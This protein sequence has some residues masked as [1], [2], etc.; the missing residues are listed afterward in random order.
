[1]T[2]EIGAGAFTLGAA[3]LVFGLLSSATL[4]PSK[5]SQTTQRTG[6]VVSALDVASSTAPPSIEPAPSPTPGAPVLPDTSNVNPASTTRTSPAPSVHPTSKPAKPTPAPFADRAPSVVLQVMPTGTPLIVIADAS[7]STDADGT[8]IAN[9]VFNF[10]D[11]TSDT[12]L[13][14]VSRVTHTYDHAGSFQVSVVATDTAG[15]SSSASMTVT[16]G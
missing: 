15:H 5:T 8:P 6:S 2:F 13:S 4:N 12:P 16:V 9:L 7:Q 11:G 3:M 10:G 1:M 14:G